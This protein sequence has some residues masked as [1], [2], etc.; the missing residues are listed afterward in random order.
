MNNTMTKMYQEMNDFVTVKACVF[1]RCN[2]YATILCTVPSEKFGCD[3]KQMRDGSI[4]PDSYGTYIR[5]MGRELI[6]P[7]SP[8]PLTNY[9]KYLKKEGWTFA[10]TVK[11]A[12]GKQVIDAFDTCRAVI[13]VA[14]KIL[15]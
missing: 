14:R 5:V 10:F 11:E 7:L 3:L 6:T 8:M 1:K 15:H 13:S 4:C 2:E 9:E 12:R